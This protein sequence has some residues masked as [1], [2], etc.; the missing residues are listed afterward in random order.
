M[1]NM[2]VNPYE[3]CEAIA[4]AYK[5]GVGW[6]LEN[7]SGEGVINNMAYDYADRAVWELFNL[8]PKAPLPTTQKEDK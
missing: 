5:R 8:Q 7:G 4:K 3:L 2:K 6:A 1:S